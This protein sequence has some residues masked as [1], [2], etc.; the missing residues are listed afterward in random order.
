VTTGAGRATGGL[1]RVPP[2]RSGQLWLQRRLAA[3]RRG[4]ELLDQKLSMLREREAELAARAAATQQ[5][6]TA[7][8]GAADTWLLRGALVSGE[9]GIRA[10]TAR[11]P[12]DV[13]VTWTAVMGVRYPDAVTVRLPERVSDDTAPAP[14]A[15]HVAVD[16]FRGAATAAAEHAAAQR[17]LSTV[18]AEV[19]RTRRQLRGVQD[20]WVPRLEAALAERRLAVDDLEHDE[21]VRRRWAAQKRGGSW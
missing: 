10:A 7:A 21:A 15:L 3:A 16:A 11:A 12:A 13:A 2:G 19:T 17:A 5:A 4:A 1:R 14:A 8:F 20:R 6:W 18:R 9:R